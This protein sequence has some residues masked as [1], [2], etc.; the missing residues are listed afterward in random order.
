[1]YLEVHDECARKHGGHRAC[2]CACV[3]AFMEDRDGFKLLH[4]QRREMALSRAE[5]I[6]MREDRNRL[7]CCV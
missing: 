1:M 5:Q 3:H 6:R 2:T 4:M 7:S